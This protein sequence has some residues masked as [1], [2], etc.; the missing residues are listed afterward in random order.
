MI[1]VKLAEKVMSKLPE[2]CE[3]CVYFGCKP[4]PYKGWTDGCELCGQCLDDDQ[5]EGW[6]Y[7]GNGRPKNCPLIEVKDGETE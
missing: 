7:D 5:E 6:I 4:H 3:Y 1:A 2:C